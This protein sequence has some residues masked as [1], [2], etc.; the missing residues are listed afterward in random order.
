MEEEQKNKNKLIDIKPHEH[1]GS[2]QERNAA[3][4]KAVQR[5]V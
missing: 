5:F 1:V 2:K 4:E 3:K